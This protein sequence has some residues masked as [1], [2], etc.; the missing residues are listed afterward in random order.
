MSVGTGNESTRHQ[1]VE[2]A[3]KAV[4][5]GARLLDAGAGEMRYRTFCEHLEDGPQ[6]FGQYPGPGDGAALHGGGAGWALRYG[7]HLERD[8]RRIRCD[9]SGCGSF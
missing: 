5:A 8:A 3:L 7:T 4:P 1:W 6:D 2:G 9:G